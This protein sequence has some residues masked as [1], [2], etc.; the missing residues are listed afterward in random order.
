VLLKISKSEIPVKKTLWTLILALSCGLAPMNP[1]AA[2]SVIK[3]GTLVPD[4][5]AWHVILKQMGEK[6]KAA[7]VELRLY[8]GGI[9]GDE[10][11]VIRKMRIGQ[12]QGGVMTVVGLAE[13]DKSVMALAMPMMYESDE[14]LDYVR[15]K[16]QTHLA[17]RFAQK[18]FVILNWG[19]AGWV[20]F[21]GKKAIKT[22]E[23]LKSHK[24][25]IWA[26]DN[27]SLSIWKSAG[28]NPIPLAPTDI[29]TGLQTG[30]IDSFDTTPIS[31]LSFQWFKS[32]PH[33]TELKWAPLLGATVVTKKAWDKLSPV[34]RAAL[35]K[36]SLD[37]GI[38]LRK[39][40]RAKEKEVLDVMKKYGLVVETLTPGEKAQWQK[41]FQD[42]YPTL[43]GKLVPADSFNE[44]KKFRDEYRA[45]PH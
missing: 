37:T 31:A 14:E 28:Y 44:A 22:P 33:M 18:G 12:V 38:A 19:D 7:G 41:V 8:P 3:M 11:D 15:D 25:F 27:D 6:W 21:F 5:S 17:Q 30:L 35:E 36:A 4:G 43:M 45:K 34:Q 2:T 9:L 13:I 20:T 23:D 32:A 10:K 26:G 29:L 40:I 1:R 42:S 39:D 24:F 16:M